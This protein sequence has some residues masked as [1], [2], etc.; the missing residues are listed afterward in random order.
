MVT[1]ALQDANAKPA[2]ID[3]VALDQALIVQLHCRGEIH[4]LIVPGV[5]LSGKILAIVGLENAQ[6]HLN[7]SSGPSGQKSLG[8]AQEPAP[9]ILGRCL[10]EPTIP[11]RPRQCDAAVIRHG[12]EDCGSFVAKDFAAAMGAGRRLFA[13][14]R[15]FPWICWC[16]RGPLRKP[17]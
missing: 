6:E 7:R 2:P 15:R 14:P 4:L 12:T 3:T 17:K 11:L 5:A 9:L 16:A 8:G 1:V 10:S 13:A